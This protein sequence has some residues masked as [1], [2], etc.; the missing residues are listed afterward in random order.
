MNRWEPVRTGSIFN[1]TDFCRRRFST[2]VNLEEI[3]QAV[4]EILFRSSTGPKIS[5][6]HYD[7]YLEPFLYDRVIKNLPQRLVYKL[8]H[9]IHWTV[10][11]EDCL[12]DLLSDTCTRSEFQ[13]ITTGNETGCDRKYLFI[14]HLTI[15]LINIILFLCCRLCSFDLT[16]WYWTA[17]NLGTVGKKITPTERIIPILLLIG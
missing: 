1:R 5:G 3:I 16:W 2:V 17:K 10:L 12:H 6:Q 11:N 7:S 4:A 13:V 15:S 8:G 9:G 14:I